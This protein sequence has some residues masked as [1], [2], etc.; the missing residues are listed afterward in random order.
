MNNYKEQKKVHPDTSH[1]QNNTED[2]LLFID[3]SAEIDTF[4]NEGIPN[5][6]SK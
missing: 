6:Q 2:A 5:A 4:H 1:K 3:I